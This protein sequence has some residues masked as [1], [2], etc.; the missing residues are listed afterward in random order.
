MSPEFALDKLA[1]AGN[2]IIFYG[3][4]GTYN[5]FNDGN[6]PLVRID[7]ANDDGTAL[8]DEEAESL[9]VGRT[10]FEAVSNLP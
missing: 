10:L 1:K 3:C 5:P 9:A 2:V 7:K 6:S 4:P 8:L